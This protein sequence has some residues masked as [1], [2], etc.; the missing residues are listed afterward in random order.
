MLIN[1]CK[2]GERACRKAG[3][4]AEGNAIGKMRNSC[5]GIRSCYNLGYQGAVGD[6]T[7]SCHGYSSCEAGGSEIGGM[8]GSLTGACRAPNACFEVGYMSQG[9]SS[10]MINCCNDPDLCK[11]AARVFIENIC[12][13]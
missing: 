10:N 11:L 13:V 8:I 12:T 7:D 4:G 6:M 9:Y 2:G 1:S 3:G 5:T